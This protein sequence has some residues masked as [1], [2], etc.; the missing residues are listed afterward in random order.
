VQI[1]SCPSCAR[2][3]FPVIDTVKILEKELAHIKT[4]I[5][6]S[7]IGC[8]VNGPGEAAQTDIG[9]TGGGQDN[10]LLYLSGIPHEK[11]PS[12]DIIKKIVK[13]VEEKTAEKI[14]K[15]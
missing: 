2:Q 4:P 7:I 10:N 5:T 11:V 13:L 3:A 8:V 1:I 9:L 6:L 14:I 15:L 12:V